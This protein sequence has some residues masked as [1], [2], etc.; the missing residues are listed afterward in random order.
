MILF[1]TYTVVFSDWSFDI[2]PLQHL[3]YSCNACSGSA[4][5]QSLNQR[6]GIK[7]CFD[8]KQAYSPT[9]VQQ[10]YQLESTLSKEETFYKETQNQ[11]FVSSNYNVNPCDLHSKAPEDKSNAEITVWK[12]AIFEPIVV[13]HEKAI[14]K[15][16]QQQSFALRDGYTSKVRSITGSS[17]TR[18]K[19]CDA[20]ILYCDKILLR[21]ENGR[22]QFQGVRLPVNGVSAVV[23][24]LVLQA[25]KDFHL[26]L[27]YRKQLKNFNRI[28]LQLSSE[29]NPCKSSPL[30][31]PK[32]GSFADVPQN[33]QNTRSSP[34]K[35][36]V[37]QN[38]GSGSASASSTDSVIRLPDLRHMQARIY[39]IVAISGNGSTSTHPDHTLYRE[40]ISQI[41][42]V[43]FANV[44]FFFEPP[45][46]AVL[47]RIW[48]LWNVQRLSK[49]SRSQLSQ[50][51]LHYF[52][53]HSR[54][55][56][57][58]M[59]KQR[60]YAFSQNRF[61]IASCANLQLI[62]R[63]MSAPFPFNIY[64][65]RAADAKETVLR[66][67]WVV[68]AEAAPATNSVVSSQKKN[69][70]RFPLCPFWAEIV[71]NVT[72]VQTKNRS[73]NYFWLYSTYPQFEPK[74]L[75][76]FLPYK[77]TVT[78]DNVYLELICEY[79]LF[80]SKQYLRDT[81]SSIPL[82]GSQGQAIAFHFIPLATQ[83][84]FY[85]TRSKQM[86]SPR[87]FKAS[88]LSRY[89]AR[90]LALE[91]SDPPPE[92]QPKTLSHCSMAM[93]VYVRRIVGTV[94][95][96]LTD[97]KPVA[98]GLRL[99]SSTTERLILLDARSLFY[100]AERSKKSNNLSLFISDIRLVDVSPKSRG[101]VVL[102]PDPCY[103]NFAGEFGG[104]TDHENGA[105]QRRQQAATKRDASK[106]VSAAYV[107]TLEL[108]NDKHQQHHTSP[109]LQEF[110]ATLETDGVSHDAGRDADVVSA[111]L[112]E[113]EDYDVDD[114]D[115]TFSGE[116]VT[117]S[118]VSLNTSASVASRPDG[119]RQQTQLK[120]WMPNSFVRHVVRE[121]QEEFQI[122]F[123]HKKFKVYSGMCQRRFWFFCSFDF[124]SH[125]CCCRLGAVEITL[126][127][128]FVQNMTTALVDLLS[129]VLEA[130]SRRFVRNVATWL[131]L[132]SV[133]PS[134]VRPLRKK[135][136]I[137]SKLVEA[138]FSAKSITIAL[139]QTS[140]VGELLH[141][142]F[143]SL[144]VFFSFFQ[145]PKLAA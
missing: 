110:S 41:C 54:R 13:L 131:F 14:G 28:L 85:N 25:W 18:L 46:L 96:N 35:A 11:K 45:G 48:D 34:R 132:H 116:S 4:L 136:N 91:K 69:W 77:T 29:G 113:D 114:P 102:K 42:N 119:N 95:R 120:Y 24:E 36:A 81:N 139:L 117:S 68:L 124:T 89:W 17:K 71:E 108:H 33:K 82:V 70:K 92:L 43:E 145:L 53:H 94:A 126:H 37:S 44:Q 58:T 9:D 47:I 27:V 51:F 50:K 79:Y 31:V 134:K 22:C 30:F 97:P 112:I 99:P 122:G 109:E 59:Q 55:S 101:M 129:T 105:R 6:E 133:T 73:L 104:K 83:Q 103:E 19:N 144:K 142:L 61:E 106:S 80:F 52:S 2:P 23:S 76:V 100:R 140:A 98:P 143:P 67:G 49:L 138:R 72:P 66:A 3:N 5:E 115:F 8:E 20:L 32:Q 137:P 127:P 38:T 107:N 84:N 87:A 93:D 86:R 118:D 16:L 40:G 10:H 7:A 111:F 125:K 1:Q 75:A 65:W 130:A 63:S 74:P 26:F 78:R 135:K 21:L 121:E 39:P 60:R 128:V 88:M 123:A 90:S 56:H 57:R 15:G 12:I 62:V 141:F 64:G